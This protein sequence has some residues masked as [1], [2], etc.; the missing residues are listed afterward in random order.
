MLSNTLMN[1]LNFAYY[2][3]ETDYYDYSGVFAGLGILAGLGVAFFIFMMVAIVFYIIVNWKIFTKAGKPGW[4]ALVPVYNVYVMLQIADLGAIYLLLLCLPF[5]NLYAIYKMYVGL[6]RNFGKSDG[7]GIAMIFFS[8]ILLPVLAFGNATYNGNGNSDWN[9]NNN[10][11]WN[12]NNNNN[13]NNNSNNNW[14]NNQNSNQSMNFD[15]QTG[16]AITGYDPQTGQPIYANQNTAQPN[17]NTFVNNTMNEPTNN[18]FV[19]N[20]S[21]NNNMFINNQNNIDNNSFNSNNV[22]YTN[23][24]MNNNSFTNNTTVNDNNQMFGNQQVNEPVQNNFG[25]QN[26]TFINNQTEP[27]IDRPDA[28]PVNDFDNQQ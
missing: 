14:N 5:I 17:N 7:F 18:T 2:T 6:A 22:D 26:G 20:N 24:N 16:Q 25:T 21:N 1:L 9:N 28:M 13:W 23:Q 15:P 4:A 3:G 27:S 12:N 8:P 19:N 11:N 10:S